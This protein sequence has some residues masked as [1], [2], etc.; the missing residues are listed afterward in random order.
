LEFFLFG[1]ALEDVLPAG[2][3][4]GGEA[5]GVGGFFDLAAAVAEELEGELDV[6]ERGEGFAEEGLHGGFGVVPEGEE[7][8]EGGAFGEGTCGGGHGGSGGI[9]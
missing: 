4:G 2:E 5:D 7:D 1:D 8:G 6:G 3:S 9:C